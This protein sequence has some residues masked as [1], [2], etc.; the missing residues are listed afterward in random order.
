M[1]IIKLQFDF[2]FL[3]LHFKMNLNKE[4]EEENNKREGKFRIQIFA[5]YFYD[6]L[7]VRFFVFRI[8]FLTNIL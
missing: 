2:W 1:W 4:K 7:L 3:K 6:R 8:H 5:I